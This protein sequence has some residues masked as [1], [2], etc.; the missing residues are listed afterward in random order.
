MWRT[1]PDNCDWGW[2]E[3]E[4][5]GVTQT[6]LGVDVY[7]GHLCLRP[8]IDIVPSWGGGV[9]EALMVTL[10]VPEVQWGR[11]AGASTTRCTCRRRSTTA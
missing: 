7:E 3:M 4:P 11:R 2:P 9:F 8:G 6:Y 10:F 1:F 5:K